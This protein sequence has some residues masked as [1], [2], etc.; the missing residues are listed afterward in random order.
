MFLCLLTPASTDDY[1][2][3]LEEE[4]TSQ[5]ATHEESSKEETEAAKGDLVSFS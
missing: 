2:L 3:Q 5:E 1:L 4:K